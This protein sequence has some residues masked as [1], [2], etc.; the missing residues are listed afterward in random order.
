M[1]SLCAGKDSEYGECP[2]TNPFF[3]M[4]GKVGDIQVA[5][6]QTLTVENSTLPVAVTNETTR[7]SRKNELPGVIN[8]D[9][10]PLFPHRTCNG[11]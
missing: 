3:G 5:S 9:K 10:D 11:M 1:S 2:H 8:G 6:N 4:H 7:E